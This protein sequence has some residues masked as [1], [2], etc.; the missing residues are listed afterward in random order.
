MLQ[1]VAT[2]VYWVR[3]AVV[4]LA[5]VIALV[6]ALRRARPKAA[7]RDLI[8]GLFGLI[9]VFGIGVIEKGTM[10]GFAVLGVATV[11]G[12][13]LGFLS[14]RARMPLALVTALCVA[15]AMIM[16]VFGEPGAQSAGLYALGF[17]FGI[18]TGQGVK[19]LTS[20]DVQEPASREDQAPPVDEPAAASA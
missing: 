4:V 15:F 14:A 1:Q 17:G 18:A 3:V 2:V 8:F 16:V 6:S 9:A 5:S 11:I 7:K 19:S 20:K 12:A 13:I 10:S